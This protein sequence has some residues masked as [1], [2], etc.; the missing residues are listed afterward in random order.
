M[1]F[2]AIG[3]AMAQSKLLDKIGGGKADALKGLLGNK[4]ASGSNTPAS[5][6]AGAQPA[7]PQS[8][9]DQAKDKAAKKLKNILK[10]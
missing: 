4:N 9:Q 10:F 8:T 6:D 7:A 3:A 2:A 1:D 5:T